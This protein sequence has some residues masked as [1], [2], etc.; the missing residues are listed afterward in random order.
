VGIEAILSEYAE[1]A[2]PEEIAL[3]YPPVA[4]EQ[5]HAT[6][7]YYLRNQAEVDEYMRRWEARGDQ[8]LARQNLSGSPLLNR[9][10]QI[11][12]SRAGA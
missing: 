12:K 5:V 9:L 8:A 11:H 3:N 6:I 7:T 4:L 2:L 10:V 1:G